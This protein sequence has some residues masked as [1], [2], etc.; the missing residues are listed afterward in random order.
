MQ[1]Y[2]PS[3]FSPGSPRTFLIPALMLHTVQLYF[4][5]FPDTGNKSINTE[6]CKNHTT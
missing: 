1:A 2:I 3:I 6:A 5:M 4:C